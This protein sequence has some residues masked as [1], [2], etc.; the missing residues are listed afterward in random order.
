VV[1][2]LLA[3]CL[4][5]GETLRLSDQRFLVAASEEQLGVGLGTIRAGLC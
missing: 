3:V 1:A 2:V 5:C 4:A